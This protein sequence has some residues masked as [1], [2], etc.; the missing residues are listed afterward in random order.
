MSE[1]IFNGPEGRLEG[2]YQHNNKEENPPIVLLLHPHPQGGGTMNNKVVYN[3]F[4]LFTNRGFSALRFNFRGIGRSQGEFD[5]GQGELADAAAA[6]D[7][8]QAQNP[9]APRCWIVGFSF[10]AWIGMQLLMRRPEIEGFVSVAPPANRYD[11]SFLAPCPASGLIVHGDSDDFVPLSDVS[12]LT[13]KLSSQRFITVDQQVVPGANHFFQNKLGELNT[14]VDKYMV[15]ALKP[16]KVTES[17]KPGKAG[18]AAKA[19]IAGKTK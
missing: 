16:K 9:D 1:I 14:I 12:T 4:N 11:F 2:R 13:K 8:I 3:L 15:A 17:D 19:G 6:L 5:N 10:G 7:W 18:K